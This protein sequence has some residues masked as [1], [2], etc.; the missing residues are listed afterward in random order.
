MRYIFI[1]LTCFLAPTELLTLQKPNDKV[2]LHIVFTQDQPPETTPSSDFREIVT[3]LFGTLE[4][5]EHGI[6]V[7]AFED[8]GLTGLSGMIW[9]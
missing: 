7:T 8:G 3:E 1:H 4:E 6:E 5:Q 9:N 2:T